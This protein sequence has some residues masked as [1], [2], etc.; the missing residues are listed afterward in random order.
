MFTVEDYHNANQ[1][2]HTGSGL[3][4][5]SLFPFNAVQSQSEFL[6]FWVELIPGAYNVLNKENSTFHA[7]CQ[8]IYIARLTEAF[9]YLIV[10]DIGPTLG[11]LI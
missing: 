11:V 5:S 1:K 10:P 3:N 4:Y 9:L 6:R 7:A 2:I 8:S